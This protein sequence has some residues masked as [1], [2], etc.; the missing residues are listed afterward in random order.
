M[1]KIRNEVSIQPGE[2]IRK[3]SDFLLLVGTF[4]PRAGETRI[5]YCLFSQRFIIWKHHL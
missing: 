2:G 5:S 1:K 4:D 3:Q